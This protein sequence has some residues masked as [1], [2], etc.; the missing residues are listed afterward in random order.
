M[1]LLWC[2]EVA[3]TCGM[4]VCSSSSRAQVLCFSSNVSAA[5]AL[6]TD[7]AG[8]MVVCAAYFAGPL[9]AHV[10]YQSKFLNL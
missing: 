9:C 7:V 6:A 3:D 1:V 2:W 4:Q 8:C 5:V 10:Q